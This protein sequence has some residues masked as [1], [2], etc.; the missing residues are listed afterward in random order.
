MLFVTVAPSASS[1]IFLSALNDT[2]ATTGAAKTVV[3]V[4]AAVQ[5][6]VTVLSI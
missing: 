5:F 6:I 3:A 2:T 4:V 1:F